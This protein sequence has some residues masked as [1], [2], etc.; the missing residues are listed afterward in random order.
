MSMRP[1]QTAGI[2]DKARSVDASG[3]NRFHFDVEM[4]DMY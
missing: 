4:A 3:K 2:S 1:E